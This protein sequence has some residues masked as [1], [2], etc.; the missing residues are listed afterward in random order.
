MERVARPQPLG[1]HPPPLEAP[2][3]GTQQ[4]QGA[5]DHH[6]GPVFRGNR[7][8]GP[9]DADIRFPQLRLHCLA[10]RE[11]RLHPAAG[12]QRAQHGA[13]PRREP[14]SGL[15]TDG[16]SP[17]RRGD[18]AHAVAQ[19]RVRGHTH[20]LPE[21]GQG[22]SQREERR[23]RPFRPVQSLLLAE[24]HGK[25]RRPP[26]LVAEHRVAPVQHRPR[27][28][29]ALVQLPT[30]AGPLASLT[31]IEES[32]LL[33]GRRLPLRS[34]RRKLAKLLPQFPRVPDHEPGAH[35]EVAAAHPRRPGRVREPLA[36]PLLGFQPGQVA[37]CQ[38]GQ[39][40]SAA[41]GEGNHPVTAVHEVRF[42]RL[43][44]AA[45]VGGTGPAGGR[46]SDRHRLRC[47]I[48]LEDQ[49]RVRPREPEGT[50]PGAHAAPHRLRPA[51][52]LGRHPHRK[53]LPFDPRVRRSEMEL[54]RNHAVAHGEQHLHHSRDP[55][56]RLQVAD[57]RLHR[58][59]EQRTFRLP[60]LP[61]RRR[62]RR[63][64][65]RV[66]ELRSRPVRLQVVHGSG[67]DAGARQRLADHPLLRRTVRRREPRA[68]SILVHRRAEH[69]PQDPASVALRIAKALERQHPA[70]LAAHEPGR[71]RVERPAVPVRGEH[72]RVLQQAG[73]SR[74]QDRVDATGEREVHLAVLERRH[75][76][77][78]R[79]Q[80]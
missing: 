56:R 79:H 3:Q 66:A 27:E 76:L 63:D 40:R 39:R 68:R 59:H 73:H 8:T 26:A 30:H 25:Q 20:P 17:P 41:R 12:G 72:V 75:R 57:V 51:P 38:R 43:R 47:V 49:V 37:G 35:P 10:R 61:V 11:H 2:P 23:L 15:Q 29:L 70:A 80:R 44:H 78:D 4:P 74:Q 18:L 33:R 36:V 7:E 52:R 53:L 13:P 69:H 58:T 42:A 34:P 6:V 64:L 9:G 1:P 24:H 62:R 32:D 21:F 31:G 60:A 55:R 65:D 5:A 67:L 54:F 50:H 45:P 71:R 14:H 16:S 22:R 19:H 77:V 48:R 46:R 28:R